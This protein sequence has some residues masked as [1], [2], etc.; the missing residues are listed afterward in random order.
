[1]DKALQLTDKKLEAL[2]SKVGRVYKND[3]ALKQIKKE[4]NAYMKMVQK[5]TRSSYEAYINEN[6]K[7]TKEELKHV[8][9]D[10]LRGLTLNSIKYRKLIKKFTKV[11]ADVNQK[12]LDLVNAEMSEIYAINYNQIATD[13]KKIGI[14]VNG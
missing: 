2:E 12:T 6:D 5:R 3:P 10:E 7:N 1:M 14:K 13:C 11:M 9:M 4:F 8:Y